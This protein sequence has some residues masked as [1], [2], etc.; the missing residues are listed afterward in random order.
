[1]DKN[2]SVNANSKNE[3]LEHYRSHRQREEIDD[4]SRTENFGG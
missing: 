1:M 3:Q 2:H 4:K